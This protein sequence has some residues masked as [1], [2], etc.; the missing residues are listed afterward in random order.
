MLIAVSVADVHVLVGSDNGSILG[1]QAR[2]Y[3]LS[4][5]HQ[6]HQYPSGLSLRSCGGG[7]LQTPP[8]S[9]WSHDAADAEKKRKEKKRKE[10]KRKE[11]KRLHLSASIY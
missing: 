1:L 3:P 9:G 10:K 7:S 4:A 11:K 2:Q 8:A 6:L 5:G